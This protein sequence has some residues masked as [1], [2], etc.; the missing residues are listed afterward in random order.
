MD[1]PVNALLNVECGDIPTV[2]WSNAQPG[3]LTPGMIE[4]WRFDLNSY[5]DTIPEL[6]ELLNDEEK[7][8]SAKFYNEQDRHMFIAS[9]A[10]L[11]SLLSRYLNIEP[12][13]LSFSFGKNKKPYI[14]NSF[15]HFNVSHSGK[16]ILIAVCDE[17]V[18]IDVEYYR[19]MTIQKEDMYNIFTEAEITFIAGH[20]PWNEIFHKLWTRKEALVKATSQ[21]I[22]DDLKGIPCLNGTHLVNQRVLNSYASWTVYSFEADEY[23]AASVAFKGG[24]KKITFNKSLLK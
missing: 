18:G 24:D 14:Q 1:S 23:Y 8:K 15:I 7:A 2:Y 9:K 6:Y 12:G 21:G 5:I 17:E 19:H 11:K 3:N 10:L 20:N 16:C 13:K 4:I 22:P